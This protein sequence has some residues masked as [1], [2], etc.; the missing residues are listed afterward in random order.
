MLMNI[1]WIDVLTGTTSDEKFNQF[2]ETVESVLNEVALIM[3][4]AL[5]INK[6][7]RNCGV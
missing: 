6:M 7:Q 4:N 1:D 5:I 2:N 3:L